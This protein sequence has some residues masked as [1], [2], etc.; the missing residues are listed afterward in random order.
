MLSQ[1]YAG[2][3]FHSLMDPPTDAAFQLFLLF[4]AVFGLIYGMI[5]GGRRHRR[6]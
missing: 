6:E 2:V 3:V 4:M 5:R 1:W